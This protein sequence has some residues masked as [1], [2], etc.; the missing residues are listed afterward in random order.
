M[1]AFKMKEATQT[2]HFE[3]ALSKAVDQKKWPQGLVLLGQLEGSRERM[4]DAATKG[5]SD[6]G[7]TECRDSM[8]EYQKLVVQIAEILKDTSL[9]AHQ[10]S[11]RWAD[12]FDEKAESS[13]PSFAFERA[14]VLFN[15]AAALSFMATHQDRGDAD[16]IKT[17][18]SLFQQ[19]AGVLSKVAELVK[20]GTWR[21]SDDFSADT[22]GFLETLMIAQA[23]KCFYEKASRDGM[24]HAIVGKLAAECA[25][26]YQEIGVRLDEARSHGRQISSM[27][28]YWL[29]VIQWNTQLFDGMQHYHAS[30][31]HEEANE[32]GIGLSRLTYA[33]NRCAEA[34][35]NSR[36]AP[37]VLRDQF[38]RAHAAT[39][40]AYKKAKHDNDLI[41]NDRVPNINALPKLER[42]CLVKAI[43]P[44]ALEVALPQPIL[45][46]APP[47]PAE[48]QA[49]HVPPIGAL[50]ISGAVAEDEPP[51]PF[52][53]DAGV[54]SLVQLGASE[55]EA[56]DALLHTGG[57]LERAA[58]IVLEQKKAIGEQ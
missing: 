41:Y 54:A 2:V 47:P 28:S 57:D 4:R 27:G 22:L 17:A 34:V 53:A 37:Q 35:N 6:R 24:K 40:E 9:N 20:A 42:K 15:A 10:V 26:L 58:N 5:F 36:K 32:Y 8:L 48:P 12:A 38:V 19:A 14:C 33:T 3:R 45:P 25:A 30:F 13:H 51:P 39:A 1:L 52:P 31:V 50:S 23:Q 11:F 21:V 7:A 46:P 29:D 16:G 49:E 18:A 43:R 55:K 44:P 56:A